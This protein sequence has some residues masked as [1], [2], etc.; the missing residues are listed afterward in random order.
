[1]NNTKLSEIFHQM[2]D[3][4]EIL[5]ANRFRI[6]SLRR[7]SRAIK[8]LPADAAEML[9]N[10]SLALVPG[11]GK[12]TVDNV[13]EYFQTGRIEA[14]QE[15]MGQIPNTLLDLLK[16]SSL[17][18]KGVRAVY[19]EL[20]VTS[21]SELQVVAEN[22]TLATLPGFGRKKAA[23]V[24]QGIA[25]LDQATG[26]LRL[27]QALEVASTVMRFLRSR[28]DVKKVFIAGALRRFKETLRMI[29]IL[30]TPLAPETG[31]GI[32]QALIGA[33]FTIDVLEMDP[34][35]GSILMATPDRPV[36]VDV[37]VIPQDR[38]GAA[39]Q[40]FTGSKKHNLRLQELAREAGYRLNPHGLFPQESEGKALA[41]TT[42]AGIYQALG[43][44]EIDP[45]LREDRGEIEAAC[46]GV[47]PNLIKE[48]DICGDLHMHT[49][50]SDGHCDIVTLARRAQE[51]G[52]E[53]ICITDHSQNSAIANG[54]DRT[55]LEKQIKDIHRLNEE[56]PG[57]HILS[58]TEVDILA[59]GRADFDDSLLAQLD[60]VI[61]SI[62]QG[63][64]GA[65]EKIMTRIRKAMDNTYIHC[66]GHPTG[67]LLGRRAA[68]DI[69]MKVL[70]EH[71]AQTGTALEVNANPYRLDLR[72]M[73][74]RMAIDAGVKLVI[75]TDSHRV[76]SLDLMTFGVST[77]ARG[78]VTPASVVNCLPIEDLKNWLLEKRR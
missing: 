13:A 24:L 16:V 6:S 61:A 76:D 44:R 54:L 20:G 48:A 57:I 32:V 45:R 41:G 22:G 40:H 69:D 15:L 31:P 30:V 53:Y 8:E 3:V 49:T 46:Q 18:P 26:R 33:D 50:A 65:R 74:C 42:E 60:F 19:R 34:A 29:D 28:E 75:C 38:L 67:R 5:G 77:A 62:H 23:T 55:R 70:I 1:M 63:L 12:S 21:L 2:A 43:L 39:L 11:I 36:Q 64:N 66:I 52:Y 58:G 56:L 68:M 27:D 47:L 59:D 4:M 14:H 25:F 17:G 72:D 7:V 78:W 10:G 37:H 73:H 9:A 71:A 51:L 35:K